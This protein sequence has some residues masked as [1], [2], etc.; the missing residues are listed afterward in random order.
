MMCNLQSPDGKI[1]LKV[2][3]MVS[4]KSR[5]RMGSDYVSESSSLSSVLF[6]NHSSCQKLHVFTP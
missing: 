5:A 2:A 1:C 4:G 6:H 3:G